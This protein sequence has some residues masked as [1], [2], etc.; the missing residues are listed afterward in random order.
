M[1]GRQ[2]L[3]P[4]ALFAVVGCGLALAACGSQKPSSSTSSGGGPSFKTAVSDAYRF[5]A[6]MRQ[7]GV[8]NFPDP[9]VHQSAGSQSIAEHAV[10]SKNSP[11]DRSAQKACNGIMPQPTGQDLASQAAQQRRHAQ[12]M[13]SFA[14]CIRSRGIYKFP[15]PDSQGNLPPQALTSAGVDIHAPAVLNAARACIP[16]SHGAVSAAA[17]NAVENGSAP[18]SSASAQGTST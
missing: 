17:I 4:R 13:L 18:G 2:R 7:H 3:G 9:V 12:D 15:D 14:R 1:T 5:S 10:M 8:T 11:V 16:A 6:C